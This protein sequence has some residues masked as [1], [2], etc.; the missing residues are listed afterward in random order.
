MRSAC[1]WITAGVVGAAICASPAG[2]A[3]GRQGVRLDLLQPASPDSHFVRAEGPHVPTEDTVE[4]AAA[5][6][7]EYAS[8]PVRVVGVDASG[9]EEPIA[10]LVRHAALGRIGASLSPGILAIDL[11]VPFAIHVAG[12]DDRSVGYA[13]EQASPP[14]NSSGLGDPRFGVHVRAV[15]GKAF[16]LTVGGRVWAPVG[17]QGA[18]L[19]DRQ[20]RA[21][22]D[23]GAAGEIR[24]WLYGGTLSVAPAFFAGRDGDRIAASF[25]AH[26]LPV[27]AF[28]LGVEP[29]V[30]LLMDE[31]QDGE[32]D[33]GLAVEALAAMR[34]RLG[35]LRVGLAGGPIFGAAPGGGEL[36]A[37]LSMGYVGSARPTPPPRPPANP[38]DRDFD[39]LLGA[40]DACPEEAGPDSQDAARR[41]CPEHDQDADGIRDEEDACVDRVG[42]RHLDAQ[43]NGCP[44]VDNDTLPDPIDR[45]PTEPGADASGC[46]KYA[47]IEGNRFKIDPPIRFE[48]DKL[49]AQGRTAIEEIA[50]TVR[51]N[52]KIEQV[53]VELGTRGAS[54]QVSDQRAAAILLI[55]RA[56]YLDASRYEVVLRDDLKAGAVEIHILP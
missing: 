30:V 14:E 18:Y 6:A 20:A 44:D 10:D 9:A 5:F 54:A 42:V 34:L 51:A 39:G 25:A 17:S 53:S 11:S 26:T 37:V 52:P 19:S 50:A 16:G 8:R 15:D 38:A 45:C 31:R 49:S 47:R 28:S 55:F 43:A 22:I 56:V 48:G 27:P 32:R 12:E 23:V 4:L 35:G 21:E 7:L 41:G 1:G 46:P 2:A 24:S 3:P 13:G 40:S 29:S 33:L 36:R